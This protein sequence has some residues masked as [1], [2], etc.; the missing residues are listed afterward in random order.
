MEHLDV[1]DVDS[2]L[3]GDDLR[4]GRLVALPVRRRP[5]HDLHGAERLEA[6]RRRVPASDR[7][8]DRAEDAGRRKAAHLVVRREAN[9]HLLRVAPFPS[10]G[11]VDLDRVEIQQLEQS[12]EAAW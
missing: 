7:I 6:D 12:V 8:A 4:P 9:S 11:L 5:R 10:L 2:E 1:I 3:V